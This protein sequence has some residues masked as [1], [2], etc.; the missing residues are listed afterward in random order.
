MPLP[1]TPKRPRTSSLKV[2]H[3]KVRVCQV[4]DGVASPDE[5]VRQ[6]LCSY[7]HFPTVKHQTLQCILFVSQFPVTQAPAHPFL[8]CRY[9]NH[10]LV[11]QPGSEDSHPLGLALPVGPVGKIALLGSTHMVPASLTACLGFRSWMH[12]LHRQ[13]PGMLPTYLSS[14]STIVRYLLDQS[15]AE[16]LRCALCRFL[17]H[18]L[19]L[20]H[21]H[22]SLS[23]R[24]NTPL[25]I[26]GR[27]RETSSRLPPFV[28][29]V[30]SPR[31]SNF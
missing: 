7:R 20:L 1:T 2:S 6:H 12:R 27:H 24:W 22:L 15:V 18:P 13:M 11:I 8:V 30:Y 9:L 16:R 14:P 29:K 28:S 3:A 23:P 19:R 25:G 21:I 4:H 26:H 17:L 10:V 31:P 5:R